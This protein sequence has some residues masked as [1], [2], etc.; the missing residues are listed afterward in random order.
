M[1]ISK[2]LDWIY[3]AKPEL[4]SRTLFDISKQDVE[5]VRNLLDEE[6]TEGV[7]AVLNSDNKSFKDA[8]VDS[9]WIIL[10]FAA[11][12][13][14]TAKEIEEYAL[15]VQE[16]NDSKFCTNEQDATQTVFLYGMGQHPDKM[17]QQ[18]DT[19]WKK[20]SDDKYVILRKS[21]NKIMKSYL[22]KSLNNI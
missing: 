18:I 11:M 22:Y 3:T 10:N 12:G 9:I 14:L 21:D 15:Q 16:S 2:I 7:D 6:I 8:I 19:Y 1:D 5:L 17:L 20:I 4:R 13:G